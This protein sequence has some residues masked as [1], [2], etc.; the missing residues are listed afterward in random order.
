MIRY[1]KKRKGQFL[2][3]LILIIVSDIIIAGGTVLKQKLIDAVTILDL[4]AV[5]VLI[6]LTVGYAVFSGGVYV[7]SNICQSCFSAKIMDDMRCFVFSGIISRKRKDFLSVND[8]DY[9]SAVT[10]DLRIIQQQYLGMF[11]LL[12]IF[13]GGLL[14]SAGLMFYYQIIVAVAAIVCAALMTVIPMALGKCLARYEKAYSEKAANLTTCLTELFSGFHVISSFGIRKHAKER[15]QKCSSE[16]KTAEYQ[17]EGISAAAD[18]FAQLLSGV[19]QATI[20]TLACYMVF[21]GKMTL[22]SMVAFIT[23]NQTFCSALTMVLRGIPMIQGVAPI[24]NRV[25][26]FSL[27]SREENEKRQPTLQRD[28]SIKNLSFE[29]RDGEPVL[30]NLSLTIRHGEKCALTG[31]SGSGKTTLIRLLTAELEGYEGEICYDGIELPKIDAEAVCKIVTVIHQDVFLF[32]DSIRN[33]ICLYEE[34]S[35]EEFERAIRLSGVKK[36]MDQIPEGDSYQVGQRGKYLS[37]G[38]R[39]RIAIA[40][41]LI[42]QTPFLILDE[43]TSSLD[44]QTAVEIETE[45]LAIPNLTLLT[46]THHLR[47]PQA[48]DQIINLPKV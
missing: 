27:Q 9:I 36:F 46:I 26:T 25:N 14:F 18:G 17:S 5:K 10:N 2:L 21:I 30:G 48:Y 44:E 12:V 13:G 31:E 34:F 16:L 22:G 39:Q 43:G 32:D 33:N 4:Q 41:A 7:L 35:E 20:L 37:G 40:R 15:F 38:Q 11:F 8:S 45:L 3:T 23:L 42:R 19:A 29:Y 47:N 1:F 28:I 24:I 6:P